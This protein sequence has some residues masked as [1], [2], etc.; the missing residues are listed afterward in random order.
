MLR[1]RLGAVLYSEHEM[2][3]FLVFAG[4][5]IASFLIVFGCAALFEALFQ[6]AE[7]VSMIVIGGT[8]GLFVVG[9][10]AVAASEFGIPV[11]FEDVPPEH[12]PENIFCDDGKPA[13]IDGTC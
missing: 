6:G 7:S 1:A 3:D 9:L 10:L 13:R 8:V 2:V 12:L 11:P 5:S 4:W